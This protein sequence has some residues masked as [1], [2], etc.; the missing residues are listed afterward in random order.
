MQLR[1]QL[2][3]LAQNFRVEENLSRVLIPKLFEDMEEQ[4]KLPNKKINVVDR[5]KRKVCVTMPS[6][7]V[8]NQDSSF[9]QARLLGKEKEEGNFEQTV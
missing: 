7:N 5:A 6:Y 9:A 3:I 4:F 1:N 2:V 8:E